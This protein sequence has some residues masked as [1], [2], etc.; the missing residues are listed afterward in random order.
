[1][2]YH[3]TPDFWK[4]QESV[5]RVRYK[6]LIYAVFH[7]NEWKMLSRGMYGISIQWLCT[8]SHI[9]KRY[10]IVGTPN[11]A[12]RLNSMTLF[13]PA[14]I[15]TLLEHTNTF[16]PYTHWSYNLDIWIAH[17]LV[18]KEDLI[19]LYAHENAVLSPLQSRVLGLRF[20]WGITEMV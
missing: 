1:M 7:F 17:V 3:L 19:S 10:V 5:H 9:I 8:F 12:P 20:R 6:M 16:S 13:F 15:L 2:I 14:L 18:S 11:S 4:E